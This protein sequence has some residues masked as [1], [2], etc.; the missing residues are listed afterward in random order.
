MPASRFLNSGL[1]RIRV[2]TA[3]VMSRSLY[4]SMSRLMNLAFWPPAAKDAARVKSGVSFSTTCSTASSKAH[5][6]CGATVE[7]TLMET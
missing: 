2:K 3:M 5:A 1:S 4:S 6:E 7:E